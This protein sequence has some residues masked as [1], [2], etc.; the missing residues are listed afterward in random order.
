MTL[1]GGGVILRAMALPLSA[2]FLSL[3]LAA[4]AP[5]APGRAAT[6]E[7]APQT[8]TGSPGSVRVA[9]VP[10]NL[11]AP[12]APG[13]GLLAVAAAPT[14]SAPIPQLKGVDAVAAPAEA[15]I[16]GYG[17]PVSAARQPG[18][19]LL[20]SGVLSEAADALRGLRRTHGAGEAALDAPD[21]EG[22][23]ARA[24]LRAGRARASV[25][26]RSVKGEWD[27][28]ILHDTAE[29]IVQSQPLTPQQYR[30]QKLMAGAR[31]LESAANG[32]VLKRYPA[33][34]LLIKP[35][36]I[37]ESNKLYNEAQQ[38]RAKGFD[39]AGFLARAVASV[40]PQRR[41]LLEGVS[42]YV[43]G[44]DPGRVAYD[45][46]DSRLHGGHG[47]QTGGYETKHL[48]PRGFIWIGPSE[49]HDFIAIAAHEGFHHGDHGY[50]VGNQMLGIVYG[51]EDGPAL[52]RALL[53]GYTELRTREALDRMVRDARAGRGG[54]G[55][56]LLRSF[57]TR[58]GKDSPGSYEEWRTQQREHP[59]HVLVEFAAEVAALPGGRAALDAFMARGDI[60]PLYAVLG[61]R[62]MEMLAKAAGN[63]ARLAHD[64]DPLISRLAFTTRLQRS[65]ESLLAPIVRGELRRDSDLVQIEWRT[66]RLLTRVWNTVITA[67]HR[68]Q[69]YVLRA[70]ERLKLGRLIEQGAK[71][72]DLQPL[73]AETAQLKHPDDK[74]PLSERGTRYGR[75]AVAAVLILAALASLVFLRADIFLYGLSGAMMLFM[76]VYQR[77]FRLFRKDWRRRVYHLV[78]GV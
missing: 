3:V 64:R 47:M 69:P 74:M 1:D 7:P 32:P 24:S 77:D 53:E 35:F 72:D 66:R 5:A 21:E 60:G 25:V 37:D 45:H 52:A 19:A 68:K 73:L 62:R 58:T 75:A 40:D 63:A 11:A 50:E 59:Y 67:P 8:G 41:A 76:G 6:P 13:P 14:L 20:D 31:D 39:A 27:S 4:P 15:Q 65:L 61:G 29:H 30:Y 2:A 23:A 49:T 28:R 34:A 16:L 43:P 42:R 70:L 33:R 12:L 55:E 57:E 9:P 17:L 38:V 54:V 18:S 71:P 22:H 44:L 10:L 36:L 46:A 51:H 26:I 78:T 56:E 48:D